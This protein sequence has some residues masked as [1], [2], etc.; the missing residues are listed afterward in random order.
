MFSKPWHLQAVNWLR[1]QCVG[2]L[3]AVLADEPGM[4]KTASVVTFV[5]SLRRDFRALGPV[6]VVVPPASLSFWEGEF[7][8]W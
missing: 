8:F 2:G 3:S 1:R 4:G 5:Q 7:A 6:L